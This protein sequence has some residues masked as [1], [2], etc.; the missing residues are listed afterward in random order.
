M[1]SLEIVPEDNRR[2][3]STVKGEKVRR[4]AGKNRKEI[5]NEWPVSRRKGKD[6]PNRTTLKLWHEAAE[7]Q[8]L[9]AKT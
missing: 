5:H 6:F 3:V 4:M 7:I 9:P 2:S 1:R 8:E